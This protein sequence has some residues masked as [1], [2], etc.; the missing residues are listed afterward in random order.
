MFSAQFE[1]SERW[2][3][4]ISSIKAGSDYVFD[5]YMYYILI[6]S[7]S[8]RLDWSLIVF[9]SRTFFIWGR[10]ETTNWSRN[11]TPSLLTLC[12]K[13]WR[14]CQVFNNLRL[15]HLDPVSCLLSRGEQFKWS[16]TELELVDSDMEELLLCLEMGLRALCINL[17]IFLII[18]I[19]RF[20]N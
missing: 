20:P 13:Y 2:Y 19:I 1:R 17:N 15:A 16:H 5:M 14:Q 7:L 6:K 12:M 10:L 11:T 8:S 4:L 18:A 3:F 9:D